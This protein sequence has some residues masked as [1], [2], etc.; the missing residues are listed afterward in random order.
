MAARL[1]LARAAGRPRATPTALQLAFPSV[2]RSGIARL[3]TSPP[4][5][6]YPS[7][8]RVSFTSTGTQ[9]S[10]FSTGTPPS[11]SLPHVKQ[12]NEQDKS[13]VLLPKEDAFSIEKDTWAERHVPEWMLPYIQIA[14]INRPGPTFMLL[15][16]C[17]WSIAMAAPA[18]QLPDLKLLALFGTGS[19][20]MRSAGCT[21]NDMW[22]KDFDKQVERTNKRPMA[23][24]KLTYPQ[25]WGFLAGQLSAG[26]AVLLQLNWYSVAMGASSLALVASYPTMKRFTY[27]PQAVLG[28]TFNYGALLGW[29][30]VHGSCEWPVVLPLYA[31]GVAWTLVYDT[32][33]AHQDKKDDIKIGVRSTALLFGDKTKPVLNFFSAAAIAGFG[34]AGYMAGLDWPFFVG[35]TGGA[36]HLAWQVNTAKLD[37]PINLQ[38]RFASNKWFGALMFASVVAGNVV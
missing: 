37:D 1:L 32:L 10:W 27:W 8:R 25:A 11:P 3:A 34:T 29:A 22:D 36:A 2:S 20:I 19:L 30:A 12:G 17:F 6:L 38:A 14:R 16:P 18:G 23:A 26:L 15:W 5:A 21:I 28:L 35:L 9:R 4:F 7:T 33:Y 13:E 24:G 31:G